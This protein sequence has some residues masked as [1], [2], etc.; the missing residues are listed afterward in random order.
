MNRHFQ[1][2]LP[3]SRP[4]LDGA[5]VAVP[6]RFY[7]RTIVGGRVSGLWIGGQRMFDVTIYDAADR[8]VGSDRTGQPAGGRGLRRA[9]ARAGLRGA[10]GGTRPSDQRL[11]RASEPRGQL[12]AS[13]EA[14]LPCS[15]VRPPTGPISPAAKKPATPV[16]ASPS[17]TA[18][19][20]VVGAREQVSASSRARE[21]QRAVDRTRPA[22]ARPGTA[23]S[24]AARSA[25]ADSASRTWKRTV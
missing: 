24:V 18:E 15:R 3:G 4:R 22:A 13:T 14:V 6:A 8:P 16:V 11:T 17:R 5:E 23:P 20:V 10:A 25:S 7:Q 12:N 21:Q 19:H 9:A 1:L 2:A